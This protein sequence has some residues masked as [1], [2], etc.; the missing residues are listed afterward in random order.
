MR[1]THPDLIATW[2]S[3]NLVD[4]ELRGPELYIINS[5]FAFAA[6]AAVI[7]RLYVRVF[8][9]RWVGLDDYLLAFAWL[10]GL[11]DLATVFYGVSHGM[12]IGW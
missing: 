11:G 4:P 12:C 2:P 3:P 7:L 8:V 9:R 6:S 1:F 10:C 5:I